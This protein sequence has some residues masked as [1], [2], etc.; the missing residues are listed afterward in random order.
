MNI[1]LGHF[2]TC[3]NEKK[4]PDVA[5]GNFL[6]SFSVN[7]VENLNLMYMTVEFRRFY[8][9]IAEYNHHPSLFIVYLF[10]PLF[11]SSQKIR[12]TLFLSLNKHTGV[13]S[14]QNVAYYSPFIICL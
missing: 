2:G 4:N 8:C 9:E 1:N 5:N 7:F 10:I 6:S 14:A 13:F 11:L 12:S 3:R